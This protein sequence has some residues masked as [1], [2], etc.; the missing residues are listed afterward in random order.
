MAAYGAVAPASFLNPSSST[1]SSW[2]KSPGA[3][4]LAILSSAIVLTVLLGAD[5]SSIN[6]AKGMEL[7]AAQMMSKQ[8]PLQMQQQQQ[9]QQPMAA[10]AAAPAPVVQQAAVAAPPAMAQQQQAVKAPVSIAPHQ[11]LQ[12]EAPAEEAA[13]PAPAAEE[14]KEEKKE[15]GEESV[16]SE[17][18][19]DDMV[20]KK[21]EGGTAQQAVKSVE[22]AVQDKPNEKNSH[23]VKGYTDQGVHLIMIIF[24]LGGVVVILY[25]W[26]GNKPAGE[27]EP[28]KIRNQK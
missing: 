28:G 23:Y 26:K 15:G 19:P 16:V 5:S 7:A 8:A 27:E 22:E 17:V 3:A 11:N 13:A 12:E 20:P 24:L 25:L 18:I 10:P 14:K 6:R 1:P 2:R 4:F 9:Q 21:V